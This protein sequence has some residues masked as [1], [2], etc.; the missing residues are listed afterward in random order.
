MQTEL[1]LTEREP[2]PAVQ[3]TNPMAI[4]DAAVRSGRP[5][6][7][8]SQLMDLAERYERNCAAAAYN[9]AVARFQALCPPVYKS[10][11]A[12]E[13]GS[14]GG[15]TFCSYDDVMRVAKPHLDACGLS[16][17]FSFE[18]TQAGLKTTCRISHG[19]HH[20]DHTLTVPVPSNLKVSDTQKYGAAVRYAQRYCLCGALNI[21]VSDEDND[22]AG[23]EAEP[24]SEAD[25]RAL[26]QLL[27]DSNSDMAKFC[28]AYGIQRVADLPKSQLAHART[29]I[30]RKM[31]LAK[32]ANR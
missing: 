15:Y 19:S 22:A 13:S 24:I 7:E 10:R 30:I 17:G 9:A 25:L 32:N 16:I 1:M 26:E 18:P 6:A 23:L 11:S 21:V 27:M 2:L 3:S 4:L 8:L 14:F 5:V 12:K 31:E 28:A 20:H 29:T